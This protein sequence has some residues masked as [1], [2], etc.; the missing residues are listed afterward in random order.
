MSSHCCWGYS[1]C[2]LSLCTLVLGEPSW[3]IRFPHWLAGLGYALLDG[4]GWLGRPSLVWMAGHRCF[5]PKLHKTVFR[6][7]YEI[8]VKIPD[9]ILV[10]AC[11]ARPGLPSMRGIRML[12]YVPARLLWGS[13]CRRSRRAYIYRMY[14]LI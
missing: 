4:P 7:M 12:L 11:L 9:Q 10:W 6:K 3:A 8:P 1:P 5:R 13:G 2:P 14:A